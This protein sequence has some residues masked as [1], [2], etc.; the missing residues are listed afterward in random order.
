MN[1]PYGVA[2]DGLGDVW[3]T[4]EGNDSLTVFIGAGEVPP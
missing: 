1:G 4:N 3:V 2:I